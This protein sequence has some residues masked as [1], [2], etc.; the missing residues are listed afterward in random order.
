MRASSGARRSRWRST[1]SG[2]GSRWCGRSTSSTGAIDVLAFYV[3][4]SIIA[5]SVARLPWEPLRVE[6]PLRGAR[7]DG[8]RL[9][10]R[11]LLP[12]RDAAHLRE[13]EAQRRELVRGALPRQ[14]RLLRPVDLR[15]LPRR[16]ARAD[17][18]AHRAREVAA[19]RAR[20]RSRSRSSRGSGCSS[21]SR[22]R[23]SRRSSSPSSAS[24]RSSGGGKRSSC[25]SPRSSSS[26]SVAVA[27]PKLHALA[28][29]PRRLGDQHAH[30]RPRQP[31][32][33]RPAN[34]EAASRRRRRARRLLEVVL[35][36]SRTGTSSRAR[37]TTRRSPSRRR[38]A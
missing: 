30:E 32:L 33:Q 3:P 31:H 34:R 38:A 16:R 28:P 20:A 9:R 5:L 13:P 21:R 7:R 2:S 10:V 29:A 27:E 23:A 8:A 6:A 17:C 26:S 25:S 18:G 24:A 15:T 14:L 12:V 4:L 22:S 19:G 11:R 1:S 37:R 35:A 36:S